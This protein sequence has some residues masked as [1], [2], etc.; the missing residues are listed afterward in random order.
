MIQPSNPR[1]IA[2]AFSWL[3]CGYSTETDEFLSARYMSFIFRGGEWQNL[4]PLIIWSTD[5]VTLLLT[6]SKKTVTAELMFQKYDEIGL[7]CQVRL[8]ANYWVS[9]IKGKDDKNGNNG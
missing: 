1:N 2:F 8:L 4:D 6:Q 7:S 3:I 5:A 9:P